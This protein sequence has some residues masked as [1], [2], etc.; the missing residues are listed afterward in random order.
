[1]ELKNR[2]ALVTGST[3]G[4][5]WRICSALAQEGMKLAMVY[6]SSEEKA[7]RNLSVLRE[8]GH[9]AT[10]IRADITQESGIDTW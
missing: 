1:M 7:K 9:E 3:G 5:G 10:I 2:V 8:Q 6:Y 4:L